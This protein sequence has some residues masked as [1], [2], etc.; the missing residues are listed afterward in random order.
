M[1]ASI[2]T[3]I[4]VLGISFAL[5]KRKKA[6]CKI[7]KF[8]GGILLARFIHGFSF[9]SLNLNTD[10][11]AYSPLAAFGWFFI[12]IILYFSPRYLQK[13][14][15]WFGFISSILM[16]VFSIYIYMKYPS[17]EVGNLGKIIFENLLKLI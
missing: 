17:T 14:L 7:D 9:I 8:F 11:P 16:I 10:T 12:G 3:L 6:N 15:G 4:M 2:F 5:C 1:A 13:T